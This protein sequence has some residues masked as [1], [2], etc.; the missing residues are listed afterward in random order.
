MSGRSLVA[1]ICVWATVFLLLSD[2]AVVDAFQNKI[3]SFSETSRATPNSSLSL[4]FN[5]HYGGAIDLDEYDDEYEE[6]YDDEDVEEEEEEEYDEIDE[7]LSKAAKA[8]MEKARKKKEESTKKAISKAT[9]K[10]KTSLFKL[11]RVPY[12]LRAFLNPF[13]VAAMTKHYLA[14]LFN[15]NYMEDNVDSAAG[16]RSSLEQKAR[17]GGNPSNPKRGQRKMKPGQAKTLSD[18]PQLSA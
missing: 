12:V 1:S 7:K 11:L 8:A 5:V 9:K 17:Q 4:A 3:N 18:L 2:E 16:L 6:E 15:V 13:T 14:S 10:R